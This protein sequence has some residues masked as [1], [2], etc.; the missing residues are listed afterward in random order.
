MV[1]KVITSPLGRVVQEGEG[2]AEAVLLAVYVM[3]TPLG[4]VVQDS[5]G[6]G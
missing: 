1:E 5:E 4:R 2:V 6:E 3:T